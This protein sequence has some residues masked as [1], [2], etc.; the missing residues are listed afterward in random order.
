MSIFA[1]PVDQLL[2]ISFPVVLPPF[3][4]TFRL[5]PN[6]IS[7][8][9]ITRPFCPPSFHVI[10]SSVSLLLLPR[11]HRV[12]VPPLVCFPIL[13]PFSSPSAG[14]TAAFIQFLHPVSESQRPA[15]I[16]STPARCPGLSRPVPSPSRLSVP[17]LS[18]LCPSRCPGLSYSVPSPSRLSVP[19][20]S[21]LCPSRCPAP[22][23]LCCS[24]ISDCQSVSGMREM[25]APC[26]PHDMGPRHRRPR[27]IFVRA[28]RAVLR[29]LAS[30]AG[31]TPLEPALRPSSAANCS[32]S[33]PP[34]L[35]VSILTL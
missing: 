21:R 33:P 5:S 11:I 10:P 4:R 20:L 24:L 26:R 7:S 28:L 25:S 17:P 19:P 16:P 6:C 22:G 3:I 34:P 23:R 15:S 13:F 8:P 1:Y 31:S 18:R 30:R 2:T 32:L 35:S 12:L 27:N 29:R 9:S 14:P